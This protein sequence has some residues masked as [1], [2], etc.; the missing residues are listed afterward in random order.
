MSAI[1]VD[2]VVVLGDRRIRWENDLTLE[3]E[4]SLLLPEVNLSQWAPVY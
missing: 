4:P 1:L 2:V 3:K